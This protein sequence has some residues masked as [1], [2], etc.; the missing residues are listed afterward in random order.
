[1]Y[2]ETIWDQSSLLNECSSC[3]GRYSPKHVLNMWKHLLILVCRGGAI[4]GLGWITQQHGNSNRCPNAL[5]QAE[6]RAQETRQDLF[7]FLCLVY[8]GS[9]FVCI[10]FILFCCPSGTLKRIRNQW[11]WWP[12]AT[13]KANGGRVQ[14]HMQ[15]LWKQP[16][17]GPRTYFSC[18]VL[19]ILFA[20]EPVSG[21][22]SFLTLGRVRAM[23]SPRF[24]G[25]NWMIPELGPLFQA[26]PVRFSI[27]LSVLMSGVFGEDLGPRDHKIP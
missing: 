12:H 23:I 25:P 15:P 4:R 10:C 9:I 21:Q 14:N 13:A 7:A 11:E 17:T 8:V 6:R 24:C 2:D 3:F 16:C 18:N 1:M 20:V 26:T 19:C 27:Q 5:I 22:L